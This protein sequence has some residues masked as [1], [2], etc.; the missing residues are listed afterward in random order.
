MDCVVGKGFGPLSRISRTGGFVQR[1]NENINEHA[2]KRRINTELEYTL[3]NG[4]GDTDELRLDD[5][6]RFNAQDWLIV[7]YAAS[8]CVLERP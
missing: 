2:R 5:F 7:Q 8:P 6:R 1:S 3:G 4:K